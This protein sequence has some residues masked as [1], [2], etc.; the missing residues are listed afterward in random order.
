MRALDWLVCRE[1][2]GSQ[3]SCLRS[4]EISSCWQGPSLRGGQGPDV[5][6]T[7]TQGGTKSRF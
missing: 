7:E 5:K 2:V 1:K 4:L 3:V 6:A